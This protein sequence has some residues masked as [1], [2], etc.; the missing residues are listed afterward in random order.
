MEGKL[1]VSILL[2]NRRKSY[3]DDVNFTLLTVM[4]WERIKWLFY[5]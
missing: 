3:L 1:S 2:A 4:T 5:I